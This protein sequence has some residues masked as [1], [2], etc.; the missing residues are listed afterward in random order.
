MHGKPYTI[1]MFYSWLSAVLVA[2]GYVF[3]LHW[4]DRI[5][6]YHR[7]FFDHG[8]LVTR[9]QIMRLL[10]IPCIAWLIYAAGAGALCIISGRAAFGALAPLERYLLGAITGAGLWYAALFC[11][12]LAGMYTKPAAVTLTVAVMMLSLPHLA[13]CIR[14]AMHRFRRPQGWGEAGLLAAIA[15][16]ASVFLLTKG[17]YP[18]GGHDYYNHYFPFYKKVIETGSILPN[19]VWYHF[20]YSKGAGLYYLATLLTDPLAPQ[21]VAT[22]F[23]GLGAALTYAVL[24]RGT[25]P[26]SLLPWLGALLYLLFLIYTPGPEANARHGGWGDLEKHHEI[27][28]VLILGMLW[29]STRLFG[30][31]ISPASPW[32]LALH[33]TIISIT[34]L[35]SSLVLL[36]GAYMAGFVLW[37]AW[38][39][40]WRDAWQPFAAGATA[41]ASLLAMMAVNYHYTGLP[42]DQQLTFFWPIVNLEKMRDWGVLYEI[43]EA[44]W[45]YT[46]YAANALPWSWDILRL[47][48]TFLRLELW[49]PLI[50][51]ALPALLW[52][53][54]DSGVRRALP[55]ESRCLLAALAWV[56]A[57]TVLMGLFGGG[58]GF[59]ISFYRLT[60]FSYAPSLCFGLLLCHLA[61]SGEWRRK[62]LITAAAGIIAVATIATAA[63]PHDRIQTVKSS[64]SNIVINA[65][66]LA[67]GRFSL[68]DAYQ[69]QQGWPG[70]M[71]WGGIYP[72]METV[73]QIAGPRTRIS[74]FHIHGYCMLPGC[75]VETYLSY[76]F[77]RHWPTVFFG[78]APEAVRV[79]QSENLNYFFFSKE[80]QMFSILPASPAFTPETIGRY[81]GIKWTDGSSY[82]L[83]WRNP[84]TRPLDAAFLAAYTEKMKEAAVYRAFL[85][86]RDEWRAI[87]DHL[88]SQ[89]DHPYPFALPWCTHCGGMEPMT[90]GAQAP[91]AP[92][93]ARRAY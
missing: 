56:A 3:L 1:H 28:A 6:F 90:Q 54:K 89:G 41:G 78:T 31:K 75:G 27:T 92:Q 15:A 55:E 60:T 8:G 80:L 48:L 76:R 33:A 52:R 74:S 61:F 30:S 50:M 40:Q 73:W 71:P 47:S 22:A 19:E 45:A 84:H 79:L 57:L 69:N 59:P 34:L 77:S 67:H 39:R 7:H 38:R 37:F 35:V 4:F 46:G 49:W 83:T 17:L 85:D 9:Y 32:V 16:A 53:M 21:L 2:A 11:A 43:I 70:R 44:H 81:L 36:A 14:D 86:S 20:Y 66:H 26:Q 29:I 65:S 12:G 18:A 62:S 10:F 63:M 25:T 72:P 23:I 13:A 88:K 5:D 68:K 91:S 42:L 24:R 93:K 51:L 58:R 64:V 82:L 87:F